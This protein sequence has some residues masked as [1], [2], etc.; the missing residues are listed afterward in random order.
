VSEYDQLTGSVLHGTYRLEQLIGE[1]G[2]GAVY[3]AT[4]NRLT[5]RF[6]VKVLHRRASAD[7]GAVARFEREAQITSALGTRHIV[8]VVDFNVTPS[9]VPYIVMEL[10]QGEDLEQR[11]DSVTHLELLEATRIFEQ[12]SLALHAAHRQGIIHRDLKPSNIFICREEEGELV[13]VLDFGISKI[14]G[15]ESQLTG[16]HALMGTPYYMAPEQVVAGMS[17]VDVRT[18]I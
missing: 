4:H 17:A 7:P 18:D 16:E 13:K 9:G 2:M 10:L 5:R 12:A 14:L 8:D 3:A 1:G 6:A 11:L 15:D